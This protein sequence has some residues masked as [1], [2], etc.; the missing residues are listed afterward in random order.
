MLG[1]W[2]DGS[3]WTEILTNAEIASQGVVDSFIT[4]SHFTRTRRAHQVTAAC[5]YILQQNAYAESFKDWRED[6][7]NKHP[8]FL[9]WARVLEL[10]ILCLQLM[11][12]FREADFT[13]YLQSLKQ[14]VPWMF[15]L[16]NV[17]YARWLSV[18]IRDMLEIP[19]KH[20][21][22]FFTSFPMGRSWYTKRR[23]IL[24]RSF[25]SSARAS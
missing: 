3:G 24:V 8:Q 11:R 19:N 9:Y 2:L 14:I 23:A 10:Q 25:R 16:D 4:C 6:M 12:S 13:L 18:H 1:K 15:A 7:S 21:D 22:V 17:H 20:P 5:H